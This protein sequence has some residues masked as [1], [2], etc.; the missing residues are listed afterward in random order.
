MTLSSTTGLKVLQKRHKPDQNVPIQ[1]RGVSSMKRLWNHS[2]K[3]CKHPPYKKLK[4]MIQAILGKS[5]Q[6]L[7]QLRVQIK[8]HEEVLNN[9]NL[10]S[11]SSC[12]LISNKNLWQLEAMG[13][14]IQNKLV[15]RFYIYKCST[16]K[17]RTFTNSYLQTLKT[18]KEKRSGRFS[19][20]FLKLSIICR[21][22]AS[23]TET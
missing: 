14:K 1:L 4:M 21:I 8:L 10:S 13:L 17:V 22:M 2:W 16:V 19:D 12:L 11:K 6:R 18:R 7:T 9:L 3:H 5:A 20:K 15:L 23:Y